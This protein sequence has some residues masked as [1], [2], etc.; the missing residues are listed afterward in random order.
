MPSRPRASA[1][2]AAA[3]FALAA[4]A[5]A[6]G[7][8]C[9]GIGDGAPW[10]GGSRDGSDIATAPAPL[11]LSG[12]SV[13]PGTRSVALFTLSQPR[14]IRV[15]AAPA[16][17]FGDTVLELFDAQGRLV[18][19]DDDSGGDLASRAELDL[20]PGDYCL[21]ATGYAGSAVTATLQVSRPE[22][23]AL[24]TGLSGGFAGTGDLPMFV[25]VEP[26]LADT[27]ATRLGQ[28]AI[29]GQ[30]ANGVAATNSAEA[31]AYYRFDLSSPQPVTIR[32]E[33]PSADPYIYLF[34]G[35]GNLLAE[36]DDYDGL[37]SRIDMV[38]PLPAGSYC[39]AMRALSDPTLP[40]TLRVAGFDAAAVEAEAYA[41]GDAAPPL[42]GSYPVTQ[43]GAV[44][45]SL[46]RDVQAPGDQAQWF[47]VEVPAAGLLLITADELSDSDPV[48]SVF[49]GTGAMAGYNDDANG[50]LNSELIIRV[51]PGRYRIAVRQYASNYQGTIR[52]GLRRFVPAE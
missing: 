5:A 13:A 50:T 24:T 4:P 17:P 45:T 34:D 6:Q 9:G 52:L 7:V 23:A 28:G 44:Q 48:L 22:M 25:G 16:D 15:E 30:L 29:D 36:N 2:A 12:I 21:A 49:D 19:T 1:L 11:S 31:V 41:Y 26:C 47:V 10:L 14:D 46:T 37:D 32:A 8:S 43:L 20:Q 38:D 33:N 40:I 42:D 51:D 18:V 27:P 35:Q 3:L 39:V